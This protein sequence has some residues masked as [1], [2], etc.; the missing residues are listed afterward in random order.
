MTD[1][2][3]ILNV[4]DNDAGRYVKSRILRLAGFR[5]IE[6]A[7]AS[8]ARELIDS[9]DPDLVLLDVRLPDAS[10]RDLCAQIKADPR[11]AQIVVIQTSATHIDTKN[12]VA[13]L[14]AGA[15]GYL[16]T[17]IAPEELVAH[18]RALLRM[19]RAEHERGKALEA[20]READRR[21][22][23]FLAMLAHELRN[24][25]GPIRNAVEILRMSEDRATRERARELVGRQVRHLA[26]LVDDL[27]EVSRITQR[28]VVLRRTTVALAEV[29]DSA[30][31][32]GRDTFEANGQSFVARLP[33]Q[34]V[35][36][37][38]DPVRLSQVV[39]NLLHN[40]AKFTPRGGRIE[41][42]ARV[43]DGL[44]ISVA[45]NGVGISP[46]MLP[47]VFELFSQADRS[48]ERS[49]GGLGIGLSL[50]K[51][52]VEMHGGRVEV[53]SDGPGK[54]SVFTIRLPRSVI[55][56]SPG[57]SVS[58]EAP[59]PVQSVPRRILVVE[60]NP[61][62]AESLRLLLTGLGHQVDV[63][64]DG[65]E[66]VD[67]ARRLRPDVILLDIGLPGVDGFHIAKAL[68]GLPETS[69][70]RLIAVSGYGQEKDRERSKEAGFDL[71]FVKPV[72]PRMLTAA[73]DSRD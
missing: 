70:A 12:R 52:L 41:L 45:D 32:L 21:K 46:E 66:A 73:I 51:G 9:Q 60:D 50:V 57:A 19:R 18:V 59:Q 6:A 27:L 33:E 65:R 17:P 49:Q 61:D 55:A 62:A 26:R 23:E 56:P 13:S 8:A 34:P 30:C 53:R 38:V 35:W 47:T 42:D 72:D 64:N 67:A 7:N 36:L 28:K 1:T 16:A 37:E 71:H 31:E 2:S 58:S 29:F 11:T 63:V 44:V 54:G 10:G 3:L 24:P 69:A 4:D 48:L 14:D 68:R 22:D 20:L 25:L 40:A 39:G 43:E 15:D 5:V